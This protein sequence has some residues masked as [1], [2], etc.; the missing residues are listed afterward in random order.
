MSHAF[1]ILLGTVLANNLVFAHL[2]GLETLHGAPRPLHES[3]ELG[4]LTA[5]VLTVAAGLSWLAEHALLQFQA[6]AF[7]R[8]PL[9]IVVAAASVAIVGALLR[10]AGEFWGELWLRQRWPIAANSAVLGVALLSTREF[11]S[12]PAALLFGIA[13]GLAYAVVSVLFA[14]LRQRLVESEIPVPFR[15]APIELLTAALM[16]LAFAGLA[17]LERHA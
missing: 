7:L 17:G 2:W 10:M 4:T 13:A 16:A 14:T 9:L 3:A 12:L 15:G 11:T 6:L 8:I 1:T 5:L